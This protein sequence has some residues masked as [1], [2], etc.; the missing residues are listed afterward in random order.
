MSVTTVML[1]S[2]AA[3]LLSL[4]Q[5][6]GN[7]NE[8]WTYDGISGPAYWG[9]INPAWTM[10]N[11]VRKQL[12]RG[13]VQFRIFLNFLVSPD[14]FLNLVVPIFFDKRLLDLELNRYG[15]QTPK[16]QSHNIQMTKSK[17]HH[18]DREY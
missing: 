16:V 6:Q 17:S 5:V 9:L 18:F 1:S 12:R 8:W 13:F 15:E 11:K 4:T 2:L 3:L 10:C 7:W 14:P